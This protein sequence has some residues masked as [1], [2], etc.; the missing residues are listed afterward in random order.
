L[1]EFG[2][3]VFEKKIFKKC[4]CIFT[5]SLYLPLERGYP[6]HLNKLESLLSNDELRHVWSKLAQWFWRRRLLNDPPHFFFF[7]FVIISPG[8]NLRV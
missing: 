4:H 8:E 2:K 1:I 6:A 7:I 3:L 5:L